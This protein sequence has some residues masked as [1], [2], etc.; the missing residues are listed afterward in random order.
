M[1]GILL[2]G[3]LEESCEL[4]TITRLGMKVCIRDLNVCLPQLKLTQKLGEKNVLEL[5]STELM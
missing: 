3:H 4:V 2:T 5:C 1:S